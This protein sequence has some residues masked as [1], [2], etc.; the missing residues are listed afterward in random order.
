M[1]TEKNILFAF[2]LNLCFAVLELV[3]GLLTGSVAILSDAIH[4][5]GDAASIGASYFLERKSKRGP[6]LKN[7]YGYARYSVLGSFITLTLL[8]LGSLVLIYNAITRIITPSQ[9]NYDGMIV[10]AIFGVLVNLI[11]VFLTRDRGSLNQSAVNLHMLEDVLGWGVVLIGAIVM[12]FTD[13]AILDPIMSIGVAIFILINSARGLKSTLDVLLENVPHE[14]NVNEIKMHIRTL[15]GIT[16]AHHFHI[17]SI[18]GQHH[19]ATMH[20]V[21][22]SNPQKIK[23]AIREELKKY[24]IHH[25]TFELE[26][27]LDECKNKECTPDITLHGGHCCHHH[28]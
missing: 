16:D 26:S 25:A 21:T 19:Y 2:I 12:R 27:S 1:K 28:H 8:V 9:I 5:F 24:G 13:F 3:G 22:D 15:D 23:E 14:I 17:W 10:F 4:D 18:D 11:A 20:I 7:T 6:D